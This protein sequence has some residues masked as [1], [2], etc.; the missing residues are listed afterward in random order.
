MSSGVSGAGHLH[1]SFFHF[2]TAALENNIPPPPV[3][4]GYPWLFKLYP[5]LSPIKTGSSGL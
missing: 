1:P 5:Y 4:Y 3:M 2:S